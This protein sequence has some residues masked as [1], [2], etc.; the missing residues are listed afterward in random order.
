MNEMTNQ[1][2]VSATRD[3]PIALEG[4]PPSGNALAGL[5]GGLLAALA[6]AVIWAVIAVHANIHTGYIAIGVGVLV[7][8]AVRRL[9]SGNTPAF[10]AIG[11]FFALLGCLLGN[12]LSA[13]G[14]LAEAQ[15]RSAVLIVAQLMDEPGLAPGLMQAN[16]NPMDLAFYAIAVYGGYKLSRRPRW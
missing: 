7:A 2:Q 16:F 8:F 3:A 12:L 9:G 14:F 13:C 1:A 6:G 11:A 5:L 4:P 15:G 10:A